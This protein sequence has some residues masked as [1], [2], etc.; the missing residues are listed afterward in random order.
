MAMKKSNMY[1]EKP[2]DDFEYDPEAEDNTKKYRLPF[3]LC[4][5]NGIFQETVSNSQNRDNND[6]PF[7]LPFLSEKLTSFDGNI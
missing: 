7:P 2:A 5:A 4:K 6:L 1:G 3:A